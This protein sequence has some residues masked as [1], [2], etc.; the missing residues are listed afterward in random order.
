M[1]VAKARISDS[2]VIDVV[3]VFLS[4]YDSK[5][6][7]KTFYSSV[8]LCMEVHEKKRNDNKQNGKNSWQ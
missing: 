4:I 7:P 6:L 8:V 1:N 2:L 3:C 5:W